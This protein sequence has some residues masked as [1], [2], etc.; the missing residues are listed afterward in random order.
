MGRNARGCFHLG[1]SIPLQATRALVAA[2]ISLAG[3]VGPIGDNAG[4]L[5]Y[6]QWKSDVATGR[7][8]PPPGHVEPGGE[9]ADFAY[10]YRLK[11]VKDYEYENY[12]LIF[13]RATT[14]GEFGS[15]AIKIVLDS[16]VAVTGGSAAKAALGAAS[17]GVT[18]ATTSLK[19]NVL[20]DQSITTFIT[21][22]D[23]LRLNKWNEILCKMGRCPPGSENKRSADQ[24]YTYAEAFCD[25]E[26]Y[27]HLGSFDAALRSIDANAS[28]DHAAAKQVNAE[29][30][31]V[32]SVQ[33]PAAS[34]APAGDH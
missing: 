7:V 32:T 25:M 2:A 9:R 21:K 12:V 8:F 5:T 17:A 15:D 26:E 6:D 1:V 11:V 10:V 22:M 33:E 29:I 19:K 3:C 24:P 18:G 20:F 31:K 23:A 27:G 14:Y 34:P 16:L 13:R 30:N 28:A 4:R